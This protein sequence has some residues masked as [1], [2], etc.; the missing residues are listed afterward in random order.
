M[1]TAFAVDRIAEPSSSSTAGAGRLG[2]GLMRNHAG[3]YG[4]AFLY[5]LPDAQEGF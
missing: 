3:S 2:I 4:P 5:G 1:S